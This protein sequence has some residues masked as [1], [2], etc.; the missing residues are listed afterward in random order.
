M[1]G[2]SLVH[3]EQFPAVRVLAPTHPLQGI[4]LNGYRGGDLDA[5]P[6]RTRHLR[7]DLEG[8]DV[9]EG[10]KP[11]GVVEALGG[12]SPERARHSREDGVRV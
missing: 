5:A 6:A 8:A 3:E 1:A 12:V 11:D 7:P 4:Y 2:P 10:R 9:P